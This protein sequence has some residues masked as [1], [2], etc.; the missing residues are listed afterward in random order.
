M[1]EQQ[2]EAEQVFSAWK[3]ITFYEFQLRRIAPASRVILSWLKS[4]EC[5]PMDIRANKHMETQLL[6]FTEKMG[7]SLESVLVDIKNILSDYEVCF[8]KFMD[9]SPEAFTNFLRKVREKYWLMGYCI[10]SLGSV[11]HIFDRY[12][13]N[14]PNKRL[15]FEPMY[16]MLKQFDVALDRRRERSNAF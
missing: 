14:I 7:K 6:M 15:Y 10:S 13:R 5:L 2:G 16:E 1:E 11:N 12:M 8:R 3:G 4:A 9:G